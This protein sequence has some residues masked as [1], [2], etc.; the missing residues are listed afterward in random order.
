MTSVAGAPTCLD[1][2]GAQRQYNR[3]LHLFVTVDTH[4]LGLAVLGGRLFLV[5]ERSHVGCVGLT[6][7]FYLTL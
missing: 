7:R 4:R 6:D 1:L 2:A 3:L 5:A